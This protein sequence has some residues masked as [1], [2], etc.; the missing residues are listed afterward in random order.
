MTVLNSTLQNGAPLVKQRVEF[1]DSLRFFA[2]FAVLYQ[3][4][5]EGHNLPIDFILGILSPGVFGVVLFFFI[6]GFVMPMSIKGPVNVIS[7]AIKRIFR[8]YPLLIFSMLLLFICERFVV[9]F[10]SQVMVTSGW[11][12][13]VGNLFLVQDYLS[14]PAFIGVTWTLSLEFA[15]YALFCVFRLVEGENYHR[16]LSRVMPILMLLL[17]F[18]SIIFEKRLPLGRIGLLYAAVFGARSYAFLSKKISP[19]EFQFDATLFLIVTLITNW[20]SF[21]KYHHPNISMFQAIV[22]WTAALL[23]F[24]AVVYYENVRSLG[25]LTNSVSVKLGEMSYSIYLLHPIA[26]L[27]ASSMINGL[28]YV[29]LGLIGTLCLSALSYRY[30]ERTGQ[31]IGARLVRWVT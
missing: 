1:L 8:I 10:P 4:S 20:V 6:S 7:F 17:A 16:I 23:L 24:S 27:L 18:M 29:P 21:G 5:M 25:V 30:V 22:P 31:R 3:H 19:R 12:V 13:W 15:W 14:Q 9:N 2:A 11:F 26:L 28:L